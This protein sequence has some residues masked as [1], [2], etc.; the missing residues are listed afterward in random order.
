M[1]ER[2]DVAVAPDPVAYEKSL[3][4]FQLATS[5]PR[6]QL[7]LF[8]F[9]YA[10]GDALTIFRKWSERLPASIEVCPVKIP[11]RGTR[12]SEPPMSNLTLIV[13]A[14]GEAMQF[15]LDK[16]FA[17]FGHSMGAMISF[18]LARFL[19]REKGIE[20]CHLFVSGR[21]APQIPDRDPPMY[22]LPEQEFLQELQKING[23]P[24]EALENL[25]LMKMLLPTIKA[26]F[27][28]CQTHSYVDEPP[29]S[30]PITVFGGI[31]DE[32]T[33]ED[34]EGWRAQTCNHHSMHL[35]AG[36]HFFIR[37]SQKNLLALL[38]IQLARTLSALSLHPVLLRDRTSPF[39]K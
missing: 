28:L 6:T 9:P 37:T 38:S 18:E 19:R 15:H 21:Q 14:I 29:L 34:L 10:G 25:E 17:F 24:K 3:S 33:R 11:G 35:L 30:C 23:T 7:R 22:D 32:T 12:V 27:Q 39:S 8:C 2:K 31:E 4:W 20:P 16:P 36:D 26:D 5:K 1:T 13:K